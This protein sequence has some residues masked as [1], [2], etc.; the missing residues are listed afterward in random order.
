LKIYWSRTH[1]EEGN[2]P[3]PHPDEPGLVKKLA[4]TYGTSTCC[5]LA[6]AT[7]SVLGALLEILRVTRI[8]RVGK[9]RRELLCRDK[10]HCTESK[11][12]VDLWCNPISS[13][14]PQSLHNYVSEL[15][16]SRPTRWSF[17]NNAQDNNKR[18]E[19]WTMH[20]MFFPSLVPISISSYIKIQESDKRSC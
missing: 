17:T 9:D 8:E 3:T 6:A 14:A 1:Q 19:S 13:F 11:F 10:N 16:H 7:A 20:N 5:N 4:S 15:V 2:I 18:I 12:S